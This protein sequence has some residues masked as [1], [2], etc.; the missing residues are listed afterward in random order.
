MLALCVCAT[1]EVTAVRSMCWLYSRARTIQALQTR[2]RVGDVSSEALVCSEQCGSKRD[3][4][5]RL[6]VSAGVARQYGCKNMAADV[7]CA[8]AFCFVL[9]LVACG[10][11]RS[12]RCTVH[13]VRFPSAVRSKAAHCELPFVLFPGRPKDMYGAPR[14]SPRKEKGKSKEKLPPRPTPLPQR[15]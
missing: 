9:P 11:W 14:K 6:R 3:L 15:P 2:H 1:M 8:P 7:P 12:W 10:R 5:R 13:T 4:N